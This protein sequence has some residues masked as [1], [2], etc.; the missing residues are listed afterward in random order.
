MTQEVATIHHQPP[1]EPAYSQEQVELI[2]RTIAVGATNDEL[3]LFLQVCKRTRLDPF[4]RQLFAIKRWDAR[5]QREVMSI[6]TS[7]DGFRVIAERHGQY[8][9]Q[10]GPFW[11]AADGKWTDVWLDTKPPAA[12]KVAVLRRDFAEPLW[13]VAKWDSYKQTKK[14]GSLSGLWGKMPELMLSKVAEALALRKAF[15]NDL[16][17]LYSA[18]EM[19]QAEIADEAPAKPAPATRATKPPVKMVDAPKPEPI[20]PAETQPP[21]VLEPEVVKEPA[22]TQPQPPDEEQRTPVDPVDVKGTTPMTR[23]TMQAIF[24]KLS[25]LNKSKGAGTAQRVILARFND[26]RPVNRLSNEEGEE[27]IRL[28]DEAMKG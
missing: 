2:K 1:A 18:D 16:S 11:C 15:P 12:A 14:D 26:G 20:Q 22:V 27:L 10:L 3:Q 5:A 23:T 17:G 28:F 7:I 25:E 8:A 13:A 4:A 6:Q 19:A 9:G 24:R 21:L